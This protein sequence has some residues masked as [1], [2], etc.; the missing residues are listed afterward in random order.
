[1]EEAEEA[2]NGANDV[3]GGPSAAPTHASE[4]KLNAFIQAFER[5]L[6]SRRYGLFDY[7]VYISEEVVKK[8]GKLQFSTFASQPIKKRVVNYWCF[9]TGVALQELV[10][11]GIRSL[12][13]TSGNAYLANMNVY[14]ICP[15]THYSLLPIRYTLPFGSH[16]GRSKA[17]FSN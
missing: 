8:T 5:V 9:C 4:P 12:I 10:S 1:M 7:K 6:R 2:L 14:C 15:F 17:S 13:L 11:L 3:L 16:E